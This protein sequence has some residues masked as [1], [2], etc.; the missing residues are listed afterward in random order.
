MQG[1]RLL[2]SAS[3]KILLSSMRKLLQ[4]SVFIL[5]NLSCTAQDSTRGSITPERAWWDVTHYNITVVP[6]FSSKTITG[7]NVISFSAVAAG[8]RMQIDLQQPMEILSI[9][10]RG[11]Q[12]NSTRKENVYYVDFG[13]P[14]NIG[15]TGSL[16]ISFTGHPR[17]AVKPPWDGGWIWRKDRSGNPWVTVACQGLGA[18][19]WYPCKDHQSDEPDS[20]VLSIVAPDSLI[21][22]GNG[23]LREK[24]QLDSGRSKFT[25]AVSNPI[26]SYNIIPY[27]GKY[28]NW[29]EKYNGEK[30]ILD[31]SYWA[32]GEDEKIARKQF[33]QVPKM[34]KCFEHW[35]GPYPFYEDGYKLVEAPHLG[36]EHQSAVAY[37]NKFLNGYMGTDLSGTGWGLKWDFIIVHESGHEWFGNNI[38]SKDIADMWIHEGFTNY[39]EALFTECE[40]GKKAGEE[41][42][43][44]LKKNIKNDIPVTGPYGVNREG[45]EDMYYKGA[46][47]VHTIRKIMDDDEKFRQMLRGL[48]K[49]FYHRTVTAPEI[50]QFICR[51]A[52]RNL[53]KVFQQYL[54]TTKIPVF[55]YKLEKN[56]LTYRWSNCVDGFNMP[57]KVKSGKTMWLYPTENWKTVTVSSGTVDVDPNFYV[58]STR[59]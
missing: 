43:N 40:Y 10:F 23:R 49:T 54:L 20:A 53:S 6:D 38:T 33:V 32:L 25:W 44:G 45:S 34:L 19:V 36:M 5:A 17:E 56:R 58:A 9:S 11:R 8:Q 48:N 12:A 39:S 46:A 52:N 1:M 16:Y 30:G 21:A 3:C 14:F 22:I 55:E 27:I 29:N 7:T 35:F 42:V 50:E 28:V 15:D 47:L 26:N 18:S 24:A 2:A 13:E 37:G 41:Y 57:L 59:M 31:V 4:I 51:S